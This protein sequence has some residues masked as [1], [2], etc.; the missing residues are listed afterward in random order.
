MQG[1]STNGPE[2][3][4]EPRGKI[5]RKPPL[6]PRSKSN[7]LT[8]VTGMGHTE[9]G[10]GIPEAAGRKPLPHLPMLSAAE[11]HGPSGVPRQAAPCAPACELNDHPRGWVRIGESCA[12]EIPADREAFV[13]CM[14][15]CGAL[16]KH[17]ERPRGWLPASRQGAE[18]PIAPGNDAC[19]PPPWDTAFPG[20]F[21]VRSA[22]SCLTPFRGTG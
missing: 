15:A 9:A 2:T 19:P 3:P 14:E 20:A 8:G 16:R 12:H 18:R 7:N 5:L 6:T 22:S 17:L 10:Q 13:R 21:F 11:G 1:V 4:P